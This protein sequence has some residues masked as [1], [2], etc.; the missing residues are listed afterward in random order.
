MAVLLTLGLWGMAPE[1]YR[2]GVLQGFILFMI[3]VN[4]VVVG[5]YLIPLFYL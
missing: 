3:L 4:G 1:W 2:V 5:K